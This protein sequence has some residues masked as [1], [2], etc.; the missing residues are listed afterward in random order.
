MI[1]KKVV[2]KIVCLICVFLTNISCDEKLKKVIEYHPNGNAHREYFIDENGLMQG[3]GIIY[4][5]EGD[6][7]SFVFF[8]NNKPMDYIINFKNNKISNIIIF[9]DSV[10]L[11]KNFNNGALE[12]EGHMFGGNK[13]GYWNYYKNNKKHKV[14]QFINLCGEQ[15]GNQGWV[16][17]DKDNLVSKGSN[18]FRIIDKKDRYKK[19]EEFV[20]Y[21][22]YQ[23]L[24]G[25]ESMSNYAMSTK[26][27]NDFCNLRQVK[28]DS[29]TTQKHLLKFYYKFSEKGKK[30]IRG[31]IREY[32]FIEEVKNDFVF[33]ERKVYFDIPVVIE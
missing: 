22:K 14:I 11:V 9:K 5:Q 18:F 20:F 24:W 7:E 8:K 17:N 26:I 25:N 30:N 28:L 12:S 31:Y 15:Y 23:S 1:I 29:F 10:N 6:I 16:F 3:K 21:V 27:S 4:N 2:F 19:D 32:G 13:I 33:K